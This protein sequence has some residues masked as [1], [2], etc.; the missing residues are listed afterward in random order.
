MIIGILL[1]FSSGLIFFLRNSVSED[2]I[3]AQIKASAS[4]V[5]LD[6]LP[7]KEFTDTC[8]RDI[9]IEALNFV[10]MRGGYYNISSFEE[11]YNNINSEILNDKY[12][13]IPFWY[14]VEPC[15]SKEFGC[16]ATNQPALNKGEDDRSL[17]EE[18][19]NYVDDHLEN[20]LL[21]YEI[22]KNQYK[23]VYDAPITTVVI[24][25]KDVYFKLSM[26]MTITNK[27]SDTVKAD[28]FVQ[29]VRVNLRDIYEF[30]NDL[31]KSESSTGFLEAA[32]FNAMSL[33]MG[34]ELPPIDELSFESPRHWLTS[35]VYDI[36][37]DDLFP[38]YIPLLH[39]S[40]TLEETLFNAG[41]YGNQ[42]V[43][44]ISNGFFSSLTSNIISEK[45]YG[46]LKVEFEYVPDKL[47][48][49]LNQGEFLVQPVDIMSAMPSGNL[50]TMFMSVFNVYK[51]RYDTVY[52]IIVTITDTQADTEAFNDQ[53]YS[54]RIAM[55]LNFRNNEPYTADVV[56]HSF[57]ISRKFDLTN[58]P[59]MYPNRTF[60][61]GTYNA[62]TNEILPNSK[63]EYI[64]GK[65][66]YLGDTD[67]FG[68]LVTKMPACMSGGKF[69]VRND[70]YSSQYYSFSNNENKQ[71]GL[72]AIKLWPIK[73]LNVSIQ[74]LIVSEFVEGET[75]IEKAMSVLT[76][77]IDKFADED[78]SFFD[79]L[80]GMVSTLTGIG[81]L[82]SIGQQLGVT[83]R[84]I[85]PLRD[86][87]S[88]LQVANAIFGVVKSAGSVALNFIPGWGTL[89]SAIVNIAYEG[90]TYALSEMGVYFPVP[91]AQYIQ[92][93]QDLDYYR[94]SFSLEDIGV[95]DSVIVT[96]KPNFEQSVPVPMVSTFI[97]NN[98]VLVSPLELIPGNYSI[99]V[100]VVRNENFTMDPMDTCNSNPIL[101]SACES[102]LGMKSEPINLSSYV[103]GTMNTWYDFTPQEL[104]SYNK[105]KLIVLDSGLPRHTKDVPDAGFENR[106][107]LLVPERVVL[108]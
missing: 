105:M 16:G 72:L 82:D 13:N 47:Y 22:F 63:V 43:T 28:T 104:Y 85:E 39:I 62:W 48:L 68:V 69:K 89:V 8:L 93:V 95:N 80:S 102:I 97:V 9:S 60:I 4:K 15:S 94:A 71:D 23:V 77:G 87:V 29:S 38:M 1:V 41:D 5:P 74:K 66:Y 35:D 101:K 99:S 21:G 36:L 54:F 46:N 17:Q 42:A 83:E 64:C 108:E 33:Y 51:T 78:A 44:D 91:S 88:E 100:M 2:R 55:E 31:I 57:N 6:V 49:S 96:V 3:S 52:P 98:T 106:S 7:V 70:G 107:L 92:M 61:I 27:K 14:Y 34:Y 50:I 81:L 103:T 45:E 53:G 58:N 59:L 84:P 73:E 37:N 11:D 76:L 10:G 19:E 75:P 86:R 67:D 65:R 90:V 25:D 26:P 24:R 18:L 56:L 79:K 20:C 40:G 30:A 12:D 32:M